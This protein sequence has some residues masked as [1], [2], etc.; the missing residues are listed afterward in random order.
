MKKISLSLLILLIPVLL[1]AQETIE[2]IEIEGIVRVSEETVLYY[3]S[4]REGDYYNPQALQ[5]DFRSLWAT[6]FFADIKFE[7]RD[8][9]SGKI[10][11]ISVDENPVIKDI[12]YKTGKKV[13]EDD[14]VN[15]LKEVD[16]YI[17]P[18]SHYSPFK[19]QR[20]EDTIK[21]LLIEKGLPDAKVEVD[22]ND[23]GESEVEIV[24]NI[25]EGSKVRVGEVIFEGSPKLRSTILREALKENKKHSI[26][27]W[28]GGKDVF[29]EGKLAEDLASIKNKLQQNGYMEATLGEPRIEDIT[30]RTI[31][32]KKQTMKKIT[33][34]INA[35]YRYFVG[36]IAIEGNKI[37][38]TQGIREFIK[39]NDG[40]VYT[41]SVKDDAVEKIG[42]LYRDWGYMYA[43]I[44]PVETLD[45]KNKLVNLTF[46]IYE[47]D[48]TYLNR[49]DFKG[50]NYTKD[51]VIRRELLL[52]EGAPFMFTHFKNSLMRMRQLG[53]VELEG[54]PSI[55][56]DPEDPTKINVEVRVKELQRNNIQFSAGYSGYE[57][58]FVALSYSTV[59]F[60][61]AGENLQLQLQTGKRIKNYM[62][63]FTEPYLFDLPINV[64][65]NV[66][67]R[68]YI[69]PYLYNRKDKG[70][71][72][73]FSARLGRTYWRGSLT[74]GYQDVFVELP[75]LEGED[76]ENPAYD[77]IYLSMFGLGKYKVSYLQPSFY[78]NSI[79]SP[80][81]PSRGQLMSASIKFAGGPLGGEINI[82]KP[83]FEF[84]IYQ[85]TFGEQRLGF[86]IEYSFMKKF[87]ETELPFWERFYLGGER[88]IRGYEIYAIG[89][90][91]DQGT[92]IGGEK[93]I[94][95]NAE[96]IIPVGGPLFMI[97]FY[98]AGN[99]VLAEQK[100]N[101]K[102]LYTSMGLE[103]R[104]FVPALR[105]PFRLIFAYNN[106][107]IRQDDSNFAFR[108]AIGTTF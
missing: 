79:D 38:T 42:E 103:M 65:F 33:I 26:Y 71:D 84:A 92:N 2:K 62:F 67:N 30:K 56:P 70:I 102:D 45:P 51:K 24:F 87:G 55:I 27:S 82:I 50:N 74:Y 108:F 107:R 63:G 105:V 75:S 49:I 83:R 78:R 54:E 64:G 13:K 73:T 36:N 60:L 3:L 80:L 6:G 12:V 29:N 85:P 4:F 52:Y 21:G 72:F 9:T 59:N 5:N 99:A 91:S 1:C 48:L 17:L 19:I 106:Q 7:E 104:V 69:L 10:V 39:F 81:T 57:G 46:N 15:K 14:I 20:I 53:L 90:R 23:K 101:F 43:Q 88:S 93:Q 97:F 28:I 8:G 86:H 44:V 25:N 31:F 76:G 40:D 98:D 66:Y 37:F 96:Y 89:P 100:L 95:I 32:G 22:K 58:T 68:Y 47:G 61:G 35:G 94:V 18:Y 11:K 34:P 41:T 16:A 77:P